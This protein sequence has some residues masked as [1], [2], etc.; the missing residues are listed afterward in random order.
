MKRALSEVDGK[1]WD[2]TEYAARDET[3]R[4]T[5]RQALRCLGCGEPAFFRAPTST[6]RPSF[7][8]RHHRT[9]AY[10]SVKPWSAFRY[11]Q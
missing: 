10:V 1:D 3:W 2:A 9:C 5:R 4:Y 7:G 11:L 8:A 6:R